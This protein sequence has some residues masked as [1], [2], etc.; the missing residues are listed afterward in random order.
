MCYQKQAHIQIKIKARMQNGVQIYVG[1]KFL[2]EKFWSFVYV[3]VVKLSWFI[4]RELLYYAGIHGVLSGRRG[5]F[6]LY[7]RFR[8][9]SK[10]LNY[11]HFYH[12]R[13]RSCATNS[14]ITHLYKLLNYF[15]M[16][17]TVIQKLG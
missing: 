14:L 15:K 4:L 5:I 7:L 3:S 16:K 10:T 6:M 2:F 9:E 12:V 13:I 11:F 8:F 17:T 1:E